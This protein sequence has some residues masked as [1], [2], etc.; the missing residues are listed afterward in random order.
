MI[1]KEDRQIYFTK[2]LSGGLR[3]DDKLNNVKYIIEKN[4]TIKYI[5]GY[6]KVNIYDIRNAKIISERVKRMFGGKHKYSNYKYFLKGTHIV[7][8][9]DGF[10]SELW[11]KGLNRNK[12]GENRLEDTGK[13]KLPNGKKVRIDDSGYG[14]PYKLDRDNDLYYKV[15]DVKGKDTYFFGFDDNGLYNYCIYD[16]YIPNDDTN[17]ICVASSVVDLSGDN[18]RYLRAFLNS[19]IYDFDDDTTLD[20][21]NTP[22][23]Y[24]C[25]YEF[26]YD[27]DKVIITNDYDELESYTI[28]MCEDYLKSESL[29]KKQI[30]KYMNLYDDDFLYK[31][32]MYDAMKEYFDDYVY[33]LEFQSDTMGKELYNQL[34]SYEL[35]E[36]TDEY[37]ETKDDGKTLDYDLPLFDVEDKKEEL[38]TLMCDD[39]G[40]YGNYIDWYFENYEYFDDI[41]NYHKLAEDMVGYDGVDENLGV[42]KS[43]EVNIDG[44]T[45]YIYQLY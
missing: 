31:D 1:P 26:S 17:L 28:D 2:S 11:H 20:L 35:I 15:Y 23:G 37:F 44:K 27:N 21:D 13:I 34:E 39:C 41:V 38:I 22:T 5:F 10:I 16:E 43:D 33:N 7:E 4:E 25:V 14:V 24:K 18:F 6:H 29:D 12:S 42:Y 30:Y 3:V 32:K 40:G 19:K 9:F 36:D 45:V 8:S